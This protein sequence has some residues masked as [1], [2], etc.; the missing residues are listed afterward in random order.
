MIPPPHTE[1]LSNENG[2]AVLTVNTDKTHV[3]QVI[4]QLSHSYTVYDI[5]VASRP[6]EEII[7]E[8]YKGYAI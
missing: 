5:S 7:A 1:L 4:S 3:S 2:R 8:I 6:I